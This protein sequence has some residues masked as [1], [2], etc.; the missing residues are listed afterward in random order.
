MSCKHFA[1]SKEA[2]KGHTSSG[3]GCKEKKVQRT[4]NSAHRRQLHHLHAETHPCDTGASSTPTKDLWACAKRRRRQCSSRTRQMA[5][6]VRDVVRQCSS[7]SPLCREH[8][9]MDADHDHACGVLL[10]SCAC[11]RDDVRR[12]TRMHRAHKGSMKV[13]VHQHHWS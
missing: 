12:C 4:S 5:G 2:S 11:A 10:L 9:C 8:A 3:L 7:H 6:V 13:T 1:A